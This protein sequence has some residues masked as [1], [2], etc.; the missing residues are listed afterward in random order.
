M[1]QFGAPNFLS[2]IVGGYEQGSQQAER[3]RLRDLAEQGRV[4]QGKA[5]TGDKNA[6][7]QLGQVDPQAY[8]QTQQ[9]TAQQKAQRLDELAS[10]AYAANT[11]EKWAAFVQQ[12]AAQGHTLGPGETRDSI[13]AQAMTLKDQLAQSN[14]DRSFNQQKSNSDRAYALDERQ[15]NASQANAAAQRALEE[16]RI[17]ASGA[18]RP[19]SGYRF[20][21][22]GSMEFI[23][24]GP[25]DPNKP[26]PARSLRPTESQIKGEAILAG[27]KGSIQPA[28]NNFG[29]LSDWRNT[30]ANTLNALPLGIGSG[31]ARALKSTKGQVG[32]DAV[33]N[34][35]TNYIYALSGAQAPETEVQ[36][37]MALVMPNMT[38]GAEAIA[39]K[40]ARLG[41][42]IETLKAR[43]AGPS[44]PGMEQSGAGG[45]GDQGSNDADSLLQQAN[46]AIQMGADPEQVKARL[47]D[48]GVEADFGGQ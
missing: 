43:A 27:T 34:I 47:R 15:F 38:D 46:E 7:A 16:K 44:F 26:V 32:E 12:A 21:P 11:P 19:P 31:L 30:S 2:A 33:R 39:A 22:D 3:S 23:P 9:F 28:L 25:A 35:V 42:M 10:G 4:L 14:T 45:G 13:L 48:H 40:K 8:M 29:E 5:L 18:G 1:A 24:G 36:R 17:A 41:D 37:N 20:K 6:L